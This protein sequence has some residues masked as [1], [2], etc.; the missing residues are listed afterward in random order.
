MCAT[1]AEQDAD[2]ARLRTAVSAVLYGSVWDGFN[3][4]TG[5]SMDEALEYAAELALFVQGIIDKKADP[6][7]DC[8]CGHVRSS[9]GSAITRCTVCECEQFDG[10]VDQK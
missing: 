3:G 9:H 2:T 6:T 5:V 4:P 7:P 1:E 10:S 8:R